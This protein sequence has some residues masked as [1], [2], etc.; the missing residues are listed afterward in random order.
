[1]LLGQTVQHVFIDGERRFRSPVQVAASAGSPPVSRIGLAIRAL[2]GE[3]HRDL[4]RVGVVRADELHVGWVVRVP[5]QGRGKRWWIRG[6]DGPVGQYALIT[7]TARLV[8]V[9]GV[10]SRA[11]LRDMGQDPDR[12]QKLNLRGN[13]LLVVDY[14]DWSDDANPD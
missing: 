10:R 3:L 13:E 8:E 4:D 9:H 7:L 5:S 6:L 14:R 2:T 12:D 1:M 11:R